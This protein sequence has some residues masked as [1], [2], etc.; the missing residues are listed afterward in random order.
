MSAL[1]RT[2]GAFALTML[3]SVG[4]ALAQSAG[5]VVLH[6]PSS[7]PLNPLVT[8]E[9]IATVVN[10]ALS[11]KGDAS[12]GIFANPTF[13]GT[14][15]G[16]PIFGGGITVGGT[17]NGTHQNLIPGTTTFDVSS[18]NVTKT[19]N[20]N[21]NLTGSTTGNGIAGWNNIVVNADTLSQSQSIAGAQ[22]ADL[23]IIH[24]F[25]GTGFHGSRQG[26]LI[27]MNQIGPVAGTPGVFDNVIVGEQISVTLS[28]TFGGSGVTPSTAAGFATTF[29]PYLTFTPGYTNGGGGSAMELDLQPELGSSFMDLAGVL[30][31]RLPLGAAQATR[32][33]ASFLVSG[34]FTQASGKGFKTILS[35]GYAGSYFPLDPLGT[36]F[37][38]ASGFGGTLLAA[39][40]IDWSNVTFSSYFLKSA[41]F[42]VDGIG[43]LSAA[44]VL[45][46]DP[47]MANAI[48][49]LPATTGNGPSINF[50]GGDTAISGEVWTKGAGSFYIGGF[51]GGSIV[52][53]FIPVAS[54][55]SYLSVKDAASGNVLLDT[56]GAATGITVGG[57]SAT[58]V[59]VGR[60]AGNI[61][62]YGATAIAKATPA[63]ACAGNT[64]CQALRDALGN[65]GAINTGSISN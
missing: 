14:V 64:G 39:N 55:V 41:K 40:G 26:Q 30:V 34:G 61:G 13:T 50:T 42:T 52:A 32:E 23:A 4:G 60:S 57:V 2:V 58:A 33:D 56:A 27:F 25:G 49:L 20:I 59:Q 63:G 15:G 6:G 31:A 29:N 53:Q 16:N 21:T 22:V 24:Q 9:A 17:I 35:V 28:N 62:F 3:L 65:L 1:F 19:L 7:N 45:A 46:A 43:V 11:A 5:T 47:T 18:G 44:A 51:A 48:T 8:P 38:A 12:A 10:A 54:A 36:I 37:K